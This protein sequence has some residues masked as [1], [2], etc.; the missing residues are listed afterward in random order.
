MVSVDSKYSKKTYS[1]NYYSY[2]KVIIVVNLSL[3]SKDLKSD[4]Y[5]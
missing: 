1:I 5:T 2:K 4:R 3:T